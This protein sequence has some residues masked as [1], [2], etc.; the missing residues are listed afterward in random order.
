M[1]FTFL[2]FYVVTVL[3][4]YEWHV[5]D[6]VGFSTANNAEAIDID[7]ILNCNRKIDNVIQICS[8]S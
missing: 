8:R 2:N 6:T 3:F 1:G 4:L 5:S 7:V